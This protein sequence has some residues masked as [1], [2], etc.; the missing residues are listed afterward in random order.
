MFPTIQLTF[1]R[2]RTARG[3]SKAEKQRQPRRFQL[4][5]QCMA[6][7]SQ[8]LRFGRD[9]T[10]ITVEA[11]GFMDKRIEAHQRVQFHRNSGSGSWDPSRASWLLG[12]ALQAMLNYVFK[13]NTV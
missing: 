3:A 12:A 1:L 10:E 11:L 9:L 4:A 5:L 8:E 6:S 2:E 13:V 7:R